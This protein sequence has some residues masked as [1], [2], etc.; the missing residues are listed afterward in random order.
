MNLKMG[1]QTFLN[2]LIPLLWGSRAVLQDKHGRISVIDLSGDSAKLEIVSDKPAPGIE[3]VPKLDGFEILSDRRPL[4]LYKPE[5][6]VLTDIE[7]GLPECQ[8]RPQEIRVG[9]NR[10]SNNTISSVGVGIHVTRDGIAIGAP[11]PPSL[12]NLVVDVNT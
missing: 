4:Y 1:S 5:E 11:L 6:K 7:T 12:A 2:V 8:I 9:S 3:F 10:L